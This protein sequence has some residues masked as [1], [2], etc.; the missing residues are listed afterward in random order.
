MLFIKKTFIFILIL[1]IG[2]VPVA[3]ESK[4]D[5]C[6]EY[7]EAP[8]SSSAKTLTILDTDVGTAAYER[9]ITY[10]KGG[11]KLL[12]MAIAKEY[13]YFENCQYVGIGIM[14]GSG[15]NGF[16]PNY[17]LAIWHDAVD[18]E[19]VRSVVYVLIGASSTPVVSNGD[20]NVSCD[21]T[22]GR[23]FDGTML[24]EP[25]V[26]TTTT[27][28]EPIEQPENQ[29]L[30]SNDIQVDLAESPVNVNENSGIE[31]VVTDVNQGEQVIQDSQVTVS[32]ILVTDSFVSSKK[33]TKTK[34][35]SVHG[36][37]KSKKR[38]TKR[39]R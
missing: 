16:R 9:L 2:S 19:T 21:G 30:E 12:G 5:G 27:P 6:P 14:D 1:A 11:H 8:S 26:T 34:K 18:L 38:I 22:S 28:Q 20:C 24:N 7:L 25:V 10:S 3:K 31:T 39:L 33:A 35:N 36:K 23:Q 4:A 32:S 15:G 13:E 29:P 37:K 17:T